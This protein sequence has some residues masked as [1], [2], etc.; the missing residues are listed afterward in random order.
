MQVYQ[1]SACKTELTERCRQ[2]IG[3]ITPIIKR[4]V[5][6]VDSGLVPRSLKH[7]VI[8]NGY[9]HGTM[10][11]LCS[12][13]FLYLFDE[14][15][16]NLMSEQKCSFCRL[17]LTIEEKKKSRWVAMANEW[18]RPSSDLE[19]NEQEQRQLDNLKLWICNDCGRRSLD[20]NAK[21]SNV[22]TFWNRLKPVGYRFD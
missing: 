6:S 20:K 2:K 19:P 3:A 7:L 12:D 10:P 4:I 18:I 21:L 17:Q 16:N 14:L 22:H 13:C 8:Q 1:C 11:N 9:S 15:S 5:N